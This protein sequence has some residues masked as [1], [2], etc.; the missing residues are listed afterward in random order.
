MPRKKRPEGT[1]A[2]NGASSI[3]FSEYDQLW[4]GRVTMGTLDNGDP[5][6][7][8]VKRKEEK[9]VIAAVRELERQRESGKVT[10]P[11]RAWTVEKWLTHWVEKVAAPSVRYK[12]I[13]GYRN[14]VYKH[15]IP[16]IGAHKLVRLRAEHL[17][18]LYAK[19]RKAGHAPGNIHQVHRTVKTALNEAVD[20]DR[21]VKNP[22]KV[23]KAPKLEEKEIEPFTGEEAQL[24]LKA[25]AQRRNGVRFALAL[26]LGMRKG[27]CLG[28]K[29]S[30][31][32]IS[33]EHGC[34][35]PCGEESPE[36]CPRAQWSGSLR[37]PRQLQRR[38]WQHGCDNP[39]ECGRERHKR[40]PCPKNCTKHKKCPSV[41]PSDCEEHAARCPQRH[42]GGLHWVEVKSRAGKRTVPIP[43]PLVRAL[44]GHRKVQDS[45]R[46]AA[47]D[48]WCDEGWLF[49][50]PNGRPID[51]RTDHDEWKA[52]LA[53]A[54]VRDARLHDSRHTAAT[55]LMVLKVPHRVIMDIMGWSSISMLTRY[56]HVS[57]D[58]RSGVADLVGDLLWK[59][60]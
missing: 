43:G 48:L 35:Q 7:R 13:E 6:R 3:Y 52:L 16:G 54:G 31:V 12:T 51:P 9:D 8:H 36:D 60:N 23:A 39:H 53:E 55:M 32:A 34:D 22:A 28:L 24:L 10:K 25:S 1:R 26:A 14:A 11:G 33:V 37:T 40:K 17:E 18:S 2:P 50:Q 58:L 15:L 5:D 41:C 49:T 20:R 42:G 4:H 21:L 47:G 59:D 29:W 44:V 46:A 19:M 57:D 56:V 38:E 45:E 30:R 27:E